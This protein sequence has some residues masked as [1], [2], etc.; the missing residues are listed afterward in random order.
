MSE[1]SIFIPEITNQIPFS[2]LML[3]ADNVL[4][5]LII[6]LERVG[7]CS[8]KT[9]VCVLERT[10]ERKCNDSI[11]KFVKKHR[12]NDRNNDMGIPRKEK[13]DDML[14]FMFHLFF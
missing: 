14:P 2:G 12:K 4:L 11:F 9:N 3:I 7:V 6:K 1:K 13:C 8:L 10:T 5:S